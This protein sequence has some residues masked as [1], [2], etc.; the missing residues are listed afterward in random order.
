[1]LD[2]AKSLWRQILETLHEEIEA[3]TPIVG[4]EP[5]CVA[6]FRDEL[7]DLCPHSEDAKRLKAQTMTLAEFLESKAQ[8]V[9]LPRLPRKAIVHGH[10]HQKAVMGMSAEQ[11]VLKRMGL[12]FQILDSGCCGMAGSFGFKDGDHYDVSVKVGELVL[13]PAVRKA[14]K[15]TLILADG[16]SCREQ[17][18]QT[19]DRHG[20]H[21]AQALYM[22][23]R[24][25]PRV[26][27]G[28]PGWEYPER[29]YVN[30]PV[31]H[32]PFTRKDATVLLGAG[33][34][35]LGGAA[36]LLSRRKRF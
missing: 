15:E 29:R 12:D 28:V 20:L 2:L 13:L 25:G 4:L 33:A 5:S 6:A 16:F 1:M 35:L 3:G 7:T 18:L 19:T 27:P 10:C 8:H 30:P 9:E 21:L 17:I 26:G 34:V 24:D 31:F 11:K 14:P 23:L 32:A 36:W 22:A